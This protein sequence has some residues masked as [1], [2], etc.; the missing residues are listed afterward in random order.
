MMNTRRRKQNP[1]KRHIMQDDFDLTLLYLDLLKSEKYWRNSGQYFM[2][3]E[4]RR[5]AICLEKENIGGYE[6]YQCTENLYCSTR[7]S[8]LHTYD[9][10]MNDQLTERTQRREINAFR[11]NRSNQG[12]RSNQGNRSNQGYRSNPE[13]VSR[14]ESRNWR[15]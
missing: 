13:R 5:R 12:Y 8:D 1:P 11:S 14:S 2:S 6:S 15:E 9:V 10:S 7:K 4:C 3:R